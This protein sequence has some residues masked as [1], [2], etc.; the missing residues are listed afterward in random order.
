M[1]KL[2]DAPSAAR[3]EFVAGDT[4]HI[5][6][7]ARLRRIRAL[8]P[9]GDVRKGDL[10]GYIE[11]TWN[12]DS[13]GG[14]WVGES[15]R[16]YDSAHVSGDAQVY[17]EAEVF[18]QARVF[19]S[20]RVYGSARVF[21]SALVHGTAVVRD[22]WLSG[23]TEVSSAEDLGLIVCTDYK[24]PVAIGH[25]LIAIGCRAYPAQ[26]WLTLTDRQLVAAG[27]VDA[28]RFRRDHGTRVRELVEGAAVR[29]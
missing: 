13:Y 20:A 16:V 17:G 15:A 14:S 19:G 1:S 9:F 22:F 6:S 7:G 11:G 18:C 12:L 28:L 10:G 23:E 4:L 27:G 24:W 5:S 25:K 8:R 21:E 29:R 2:V 26:K 3:Y